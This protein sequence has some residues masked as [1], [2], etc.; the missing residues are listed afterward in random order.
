[1]EARGA[2]PVFVIPGEEVVADWDLMYYF[3]ILAREDGWF[4]PDPQTATP[5]I[6]V[7]VQT[8]EAAQ[9]AGTANSASGSA[10]KSVP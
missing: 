2:Q 7:P 1:L 8:G 5:Y 3:E 9:A 10:K 4:Y 6:V